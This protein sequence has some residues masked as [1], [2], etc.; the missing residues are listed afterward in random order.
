MKT[1]LTLLF[2][3]GLGYFLGARAGRNRYH[4]ICKIANKVWNT[5][6]VQGGVGAVSDFAS[7]RYDDVRELVGDKVGAAIAGKKNSAKKAAN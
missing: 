3:F 7:D 2:G 6:V 4:Q 5:P 1:K